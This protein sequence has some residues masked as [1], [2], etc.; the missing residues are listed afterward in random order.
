MNDSCS[1]KFITISTP[2]AGYIQNC[3]LKLRSDDQEPESA[4]QKS[5]S[6]FCFAPLLFICLCKLRSPTF[7]P[8]K[9][10]CKAVV[11]ALQFISDFRVYTRK[12][13][14]RY[15]FHF[16]DKFCIV[17]EDNIRTFHIYRVYKIST[18]I[19]KIFVP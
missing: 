2:V 9:Y 3:F 7:S 4:K 16:C 1:S 13:D 6:E 18:N 12:S 17:V 5:H 15:K 10:E 14:I 11:T 8:T 19:H